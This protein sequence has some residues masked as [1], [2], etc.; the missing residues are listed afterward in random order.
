MSTVPVFE[1]EGVLPRLA[2]SRSPLA[3]RDLA[4]AAAT[5]VGRP[6]PHAR[7]FRPEAV[8]PDACPGWCTTLR[9]P[10]LGKRFVAVIRGAVKTH[11]QSPR[12]PS[13]KHQVTG[14]IAFSAKSAAHFQHTGEP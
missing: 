12:R 1:D 11:R 10:R 7:C 6:V 2:S 5:I 9:S 13:G 14:G 4:R 8:H 3:T